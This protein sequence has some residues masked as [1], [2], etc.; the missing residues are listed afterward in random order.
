MPYRRRYFPFLSVPTNEIQDLAITPSKI[1][2]GAVTGPKIANGSVDSDALAEG[3]VTPTK[4]PAASITG[5]KL[6]AGT[7]GLTNIA[8]TP[9]TRPLSPALATAEIADGAITAA[10]LAA[11]AVS[12]TTLTDR[13]V[14]G[15][16][17]VLHDITSDELAANSVG[18]EELEADSVGETELRDNAISLIKMQDESVDTPELVDDAVETDKLDDEAVQKRHLLKTLRANLLFHDPTQG[19]VLDNLWAESG[20]AGGLAD[21]IQGRY[22]LI[23]DADAN[24]KWRINHNSRVHWKAEDML[25]TMQFR[26][27]SDIT[28]IKVFAGFYISA[29]N[30]FGI[31]FDTSVDNNIYLV[32]RVGG[33]ETAVDTG[34]AIS[35]TLQDIKIEYV[36]SSL[37]N[38]YID[39]DDNR[40]V[41]SATNIPTGRFEPQF[42]VETLAAAIKKL[43]ISNITIVSNADIGA[44]TP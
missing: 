6:A 2:A 30:Y 37:V 9:I 10:K 32:T 28:D 39:D 24:D 12:G 7:V 34:K 5:A 29:N 19:A 11:G 1:A 8:W 35:A 23:T 13:T 16:K 15:V 44:I 40:L 18:N 21:N 26:M 41:F 31:R 17:I 38:I 25:P 33:V 27:A 42:E 36:S 22:R 3:A 14:A 4:I 43:Y 20:E